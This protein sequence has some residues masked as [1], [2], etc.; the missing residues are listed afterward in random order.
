M[1]MQ[2]GNVG[3][4]FNCQGIGMTTRAQ[5]IEGFKKHQQI[6]ERKVVSFSYTKQGSLTWKKK[7]KK[8]NEVIIAKP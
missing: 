8:E 5:R 4:F 3:T 7:K 1:E 2:C 6:D